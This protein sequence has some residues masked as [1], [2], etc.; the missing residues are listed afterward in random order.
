MKKFFIY[1]LIILAG[2]VLP[3]Q[4]PASKSKKAID[5]YNQGL[6]SYSI[7]SYSNA[8]QFFLTA[9]KEDNTFIEAYLVLAE[10]YEDWKKPQNA[11]EIYRRGLPIKESFYPYGY[12]RLGNLQFREGLY[13][14]AMESYKQFLDLDKTNQ[15]HIDKAHDGILRCEFALKAIK[16]PVDFHPVN[17][18]PKVNTS[19]DEY[20]PTLSADEKTL[21]ITRMVDSDEFMKEVQ[22]DFYIST[23]Q[24]SSW[25]EMKNAGRPLNTGDNE[26]AQSITGDGRYMIFTACNR[27]DGLGRCDL[28]ESVFEGERWS[29][30][31]NIGTPVNSKYRETQPSL[32]TDGRTLYFSSDRPG[33]KGYHDIWVSH[34]EDNGQWTPPVNLGDSI[35]SAGV[36]MSPFIHPDNNSLYFSSD[37]FL[38]LGGYDLFISRMDSMGQWKS[39][40]NL[41]YPI[42]TNRDE[43]GLIVNARGDK[44]YYASDID[45]SKG[46]DIYVFDLPVEMRPNTVT[47]MKGLVF[48]EKTRKP[49]KAEFELVDL[50]TGKTVFDAYSDSL[51]G[52]FLVS[53]P[54]SR[55]YMLNVSRKSYL[56]FSENFSLKNMFVADRPF[57]KDIPLQPI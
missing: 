50:E 21:V 14:D 2:S 30:P 12:I 28:Y 10:V 40:E 24:D 9:I 38:G 39:P 26:G 44:A 3:A 11:I 7:N 55:N 46:K 27:S 18:G 47:Y 48:D 34:R 6:R 37:G 4:E 49:L 1:I 25:T 32:S 43:I 53:I 33:G 56:F 51:T 42:N 31:K 29:I 23:W 13:S 22:E 15:N 41:G 45:K 36:E 57:L 16:N 17:L 52:E 20:W 8:E 19:R 5:A 35:N 54:V